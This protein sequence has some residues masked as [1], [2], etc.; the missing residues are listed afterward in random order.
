[1]FWCYDFVFTLKLENG[2]SFRVSNTS[3]KHDGFDSVFLGFR[4]KAFLYCI[5]KAKIR[6]VT[7]VIY[8]SF[9]RVRIATISKYWCCVSPKVVIYFTKTW[10]KKFGLNR[11]NS[12]CA[13][14]I[15]TFCEKNYEFV[16][17]KICFCEKTSNVLRKNKLSYF[18]MKMVLLRY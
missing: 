2:W 9:L 18:E 8:L 3:V 4:L 1:M 15:L 7:F 16:R 6:L 10:E 14:K 5:A 13:K 17:K 12:H 11:K